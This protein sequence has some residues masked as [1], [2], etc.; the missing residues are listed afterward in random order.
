MLTILLVEKEKSSWNNTTDLLLRNQH[1]VTQCS[2]REQAL[3]KMRSESFDLIIIDLNISPRDGISLLT[4]AKK[5]LPTAEVIFISALDSVDIAVKAMKKG[6]FD[7]LEK[8]FKSEQLL[9]SVNRI[10]E[11]LRLE[12]EQANPRDEWMEKHDF[13]AII[14]KSKSMID[15]LEIV[16]QVS[17]TDTTIL[18]YGESGTGKELVARA[19]HT[20]SPRRDNEMIAVN[21]G[22]LPESLQES[23][24]FGH[25]KG[26]FTGAIK[27]KKGLFEEAHNGT[28]FLDEIGEMSLSAQV[29]LLRF[30]Q[31]GEIRR[32]GDNHPIRVDVRL[33]AAT[34]KHL[35]SEVEANR[36]RQDLFYRLSVIPIHLP[37]L[38]E[39]RSDIQLL[40]D[41]FI[42]KY[43]TKLGKNIQAVSEK[44][45]RVLNNYDWPGNVR[46]LE[47]AIERAVV[48]TK[49][50]EIIHS[51]LP[52][53]ITRNHRTP[54]AREM[55]LGLTLEEVVKRHI[56]NT[57]Q[58]SENNLME[59]ALRLG[60]SQSALFSK[61][62]E[63]EMDT[64]HETSGSNVDLLAKEIDIPTSASRQARRA[65]KGLSTILVDIG[66]TLSELE[67]KYIIKILE[68]T[69][70][71]KR[72]ASRLL[73]IS[74]VTLWRKLREL[75]VSEFDYK[76]PHLK[77]ASDRSQ[78]VSSYKTLNYADVIDRNLSNY[79]ENAT[80]QGFTLS[81]LEDQHILDTLHASKG[82]KQDT[83]FRLGISKVTLWRKLK[84][85]QDSNGNS[86]EEEFD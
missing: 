9:R 3:A 45:M 75:K 42:N 22:A 40:V 17:Q 10:E 37:P 41:H 80:E 15:V 18:I 73:G 52:E 26:S 16:S 12:N 34:N 53:Q 56:L 64:D 29:K 68:S 50:E 58:D 49:G 71:N 82:R 43:C 46:E 76:F 4:Y 33:I 74:Y 24:L 79:L 21:C 69:G 23:E 36:F 14:G 62:K 35:E 51:V 70:G 28:A 7:F 2:G 19:L 30:L 54:S 31:D 20:N 60:I 48:L 77:A 38:R 11:K 6:A 84:V 83:A 25:A 63:Y 39:R 44:A 81:Q 61:I 1:S 67:K 85:L 59:A 13:N 65:Q 55:F 47:N 8:P 32:V 5:L 66:L 86:I 78:D 27:D 72:K 57:L